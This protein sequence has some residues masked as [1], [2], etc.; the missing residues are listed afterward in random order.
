MPSPGAAATL[1]ADDV[2]CSGETPGAAV[3][4]LHHHIRPSAGAA[5]PTSDGSD[6]RQ[7]GQDPKRRRFRAFSPPPGSV[8]QEEHQEILQA[9]SD[10]EK[11]FAFDAMSSSELPELT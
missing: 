5:R 6:T 10:R 2:F 8:R 4:L 1:P 3:R 7:M 9:G 11:S